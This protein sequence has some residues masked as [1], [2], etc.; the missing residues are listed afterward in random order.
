MVEFRLKRHAISPRKEVV[1]VW[2]N[3]IFRATLYPIEPN[4]VR[5]ISAHLIEDPKKEDIGQTPILDVW[6]FEFNGS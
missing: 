5:L 1:E 4:A 6:R 3:G 2:V